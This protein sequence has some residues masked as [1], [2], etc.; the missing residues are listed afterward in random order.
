MI[1]F[2]RSLT[3]IDL[4]GIPD[5]AWI[6]TATRLPARSDSANPTNLPSGDTATTSAPSRSRRFSELGPYSSS[7]VAQIVDVFSK[8][9]QADQSD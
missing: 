7:R 5:A 1:A 6:L 9:S 4:C 3:H 2:T 8:P